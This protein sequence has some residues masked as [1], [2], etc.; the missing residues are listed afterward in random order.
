MH[1]M[2]EKEHYLA[3]HLEF[4]YSVCLSPLLQPYNLDPKDYGLVQSQKL[5]VST[6]LGDHQKD[7]IAMQKTMVNHL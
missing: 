7:G 1:W 6:G 5:W 2:P 4:L 3:S